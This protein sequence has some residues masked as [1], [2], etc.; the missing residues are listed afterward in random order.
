MASHTFDAFIGHESSSGS[1]APPDQSSYPAPPKRAFSRTYHSVPLPKNPEAL[2]LDSL[3]WGAN[4]SG[5]ATP[6]GAATPAP[7]LNDLEMSRPASPTINEHNGVEAL[8]SFSH[9]PE[10]RYRMVSI[11]M[12]NFL[13]GLS[14]SAPGALIPYIEN[15]Y[16]IGYAFVSLIFVTTALGFITAALFVEALRVYLGRA[17]SLILANFFIACAYTVIVC[18]PPWPVVVAS[19]FLMGFGM[20]VNLALGNVFSANLSNATTM[21]GFMHGSYGAGGTIGPLISTAIASSGALWSRYYLLT[22]ALTLFNLAFGG[23]SFWNYEAEQSTLFAISLDRV[24]SSAKPIAQ[25]KNMLKAL[26]TKTVIIGALFIFAYQGSEVSISGWVISFLISARNGDPKSIGYVT[27]GFWSGVTIG[28]FFLSPVAHKVGEKP[29]VYAMIIGAAVF[30]LLVWQV[31]NVIGDAVALCIVGLLLGPI[32]PC[33][34]VIFLK[35]IRKKDQVSSLSAISA[36][37]SSGGAVAPFTTGILAQAFGAFVLHP[38]AIGL[39]AV[40][41][42]CWFGLPSGQKR[43]E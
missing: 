17:K 21:L 25:L 39:F 38:I 40:M 27:S 35:A 2:E 3:E 5:P 4:R 20:A 43:T 10:N 19:F 42:V 34:V 23:W 12:M 13:S 22:L 29:F 11:C 8:Q 7:L 32:Y 31:P 6:S 26:R 33:A 30:E 14:D 24:A 37:G 1:Q 9:P 16:G 36:F 15:Y 41:V 18:T 28:R